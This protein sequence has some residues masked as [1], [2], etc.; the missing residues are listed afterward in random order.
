VNARV[1][2]LQAQLEE[3]LI[4]TNPVNVR[5]LTGFESSNAALVVDPERVRL[6]TDFRYAEAARA[7]A[8]V[9]YVQTARSLIADIGAAL[10]G[11]VA[12]E[13]ADLTYDRYET[14]RDAGLELVPRPDAV[15][16]LRALK[17]EEEVAAI[18]RAVEVADAA[19]AA[20]AQEPFVGRSERDLAWRLHELLHEH[21]AHDLS[22]E[23][24]VGSGPTGALPHGR[25]TDRIVQ[26]G[27]LVVVDW[28]ARVGDY[29]SDCTRTFA[30]G[31]LPDELARA[32]EICRA[33]QQAAL[34]GIR[35]GMTGR[36]ADA[37]AREPIAAAGF[38][39]NFGHGLG[40]GLG[41]D[42]HETPGLRPESDDVLEP[43]MIVTVEPGIYLPGV[44]GVRIEDLC[45]VREDGLE[46]LTGLPKELVTVG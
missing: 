24:I 12:F 17:D 42:V 2:R 46:T 25:P 9:E 18:R 20:F 16:G 15:E 44:G 41:M 4:V 38:G 21:G 27:E 8:G 13:A 30:T 7:L 19:V 5:Y 45:V 1:Q 11:R 28:G 29:V 43:G 6:F 10:S 14:L 36:E 22:F 31:P 23:S 35:P 34:D 26:A 32:Y 33:A 40:H 37:L 39:D 3:P